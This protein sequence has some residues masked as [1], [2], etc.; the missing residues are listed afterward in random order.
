[1]KEAWK[2]YQTA[3]SYSYSDLKEKARNNRLW[4]TMAER[5]LWNELK[6]NKLGIRFRRQHIIG[7]YIVDFFCVQCNFVIEVDGDYHGDEEQIEADNY[8]DWYLNQRG[9]KVIHFT[10]HQVEDDVETVVTK[11]IKA[12]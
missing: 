12:L 6:N 10:N 3:N 5:K 9:Y 2:K 11:I 4:M 7:N 8:R 1:M